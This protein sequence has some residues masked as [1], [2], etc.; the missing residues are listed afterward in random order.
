MRYGSPPVFFS[1]NIGFKHW[2]VEKEDGGIRN[3][4]TSNKFNNKIATKFATI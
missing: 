4:A 3:C 2:D 1:Y